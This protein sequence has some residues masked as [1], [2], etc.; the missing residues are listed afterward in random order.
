MG[1]RERERKGKSKYLFSLL[2][3]GGERL[4]FL[5]SQYDRESGR[6]SDTLEVFSR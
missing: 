4:N 2:K 1:K 6:A 3:L 5:L